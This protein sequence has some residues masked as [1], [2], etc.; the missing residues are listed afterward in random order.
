MVSITAASA[1]LRWEAAIFY[2]V[3]R[4]PS[5]LDVWYIDFV[6]EGVYILYQNAHHWACSFVPVMI[7]CVHPTLVSARFSVQRLW[8]SEFALNLSR[9]LCDLVIAI[10]KDAK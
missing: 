10:T 8:G 5:S 3:F 9:T 6:W 7:L 4:D 2:L 1:S